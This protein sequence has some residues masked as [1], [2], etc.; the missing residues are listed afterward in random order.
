MGVSDQ[1]WP[2]DLGNRC[3][4]GTYE[5][6]SE[7]EDAT[8]SHSGVFLASSGKWS[9]KSTSGFDDTDGGNYTLQS[10]NVMVMTG[11]LGTGTWTRVSK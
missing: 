9:L 5:F 4:N 11:K 2:V 3:A 7:A 8:P 10:S 1:P 6:H